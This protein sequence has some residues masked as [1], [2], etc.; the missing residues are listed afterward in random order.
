[1]QFRRVLKDIGTAREVR[2]IHDDQNIIRRLSRKQFRRVLKH[3][4]TAREVKE[5]H[6]DQNIIRR[7]SRK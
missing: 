4:D 7:L 1:M 3:I 2:E 6:D 5:I